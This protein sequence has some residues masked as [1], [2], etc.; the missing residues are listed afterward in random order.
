MLHPKT[1]SALAGGIVLSV[2]FGA[3]SANATPASACD[4]VAGNLIH[5]CGFETGTFSSWNKNTP[6]GPSNL[7]VTTPGYTGNDKA[8]FSGGVG[9]TTPSVDTLSQGFATAPGH[10]YELTFEYTFNGATPNGAFVGYFDT[11]F[12]TLSSNSDIPLTDWSLADFTFSTITTN[13]ILFIGGND[14]NGQF[15]VDDFVIKDITPVPEPLTL[16][17]FGAGI[18]GAAALRRKRKNKSV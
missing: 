5:N 6:T 16:S 14:P 10:L 15:S 18:A 12:H 17:L 3:G 2:L 4:L 9:E 7:T 11:V 13:T 8:S 1:Y